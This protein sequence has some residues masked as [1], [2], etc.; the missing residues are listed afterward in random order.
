M[1]PRLTRSRDYW[2][3]GT[4]L[5]G[6]HVLLM[7]ICYYVAVPRTFFPLAVSLLTLSTRGAADDTQALESCLTGYQGGQLEAY[8]G[9]LLTARARMA[10]C[11]AS[12]CPSTVRAECE[13]LLQQITR[14]IPSVLVV[15]RDGARG[16]SPRSVSID[17]APVSVNGLPIELDPGEHEF[18]VRGLEP[19]RVRRNVT[20]GNGS[21]RIEFL[22]PEVSKRPTVA[23]GA[24][25]GTSVLAASSFAYF[26]LDAIGRRHDLD[27]CKGDC[28]PRRVDAAFYRFV[29]ADVSLGVGLVTLGIAAWLWFRSP[30][31]TPNRAQLNLVHF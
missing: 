19:E 27:A 29:A 18:S 24:L 30:S 6:P 12:S 8:H 13:P 20:E 3:L 26:G 23:I 10:Q 2:G 25:V 4:G 1:L 5:L 9:R 31:P 28:D 17:G 11:M 15:C 22:C 21:Q 14:R 16:P 7:S